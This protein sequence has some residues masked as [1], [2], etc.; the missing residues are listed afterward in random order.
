MAKLRRILMW[1]TL[2]GMVNLTQLAALSAFIGVEKAWVLFNSVPLMLSWVALT[3]ML[4]V[5]FT[6][7]RR[8]LRTPGLLAMHLGCVLI[9]VGGMLSSKLGLKLADMWSPH[10]RVFEGNM[11]KLYDGEFR[12]DVT[13]NMGRQFDELPFEIGCEKFAIEY[14]PYPLDHGKLSIAV[15]N[16]TIKTGRWR[17]GREKEEQ[18]SKVKRFKWK[19]DKWVKL[20]LGDDIEIRV[21]E[22][23]IQ[24]AVTEPFLLAKSPA[25][26][27]HAHG[28]GVQVIPIPRGAESPEFEVAGSHGGKLI[29]RVRRVYQSYWVPH[30]MMPGQLREVEGH[31]PG[32]KPAAE[33]ELWQH[34]GTTFVYTKKLMAGFG[35]EK[36][37]APCRYVPQDQTKAETGT[38]HPGPIIIAEPPGREKEIV[39]ARV[40]Q[41]FTFMPA[42]HMRQGVI[43]RIR[44]LCFVRLVGDADSP[45][46]PEVSEAVATDPGA[47]PA[48]EIDLLV[49][50]TPERAYSPGVVADLAR[51]GGRTGMFTYVGPDDPKKMK[52]M[53]RPI[54]TFQARRR[55]FIDERTITI[56]KAQQ[57]G[58]VH[59]DFLYDDEEAWFK[60]GAP[61]VFAADE[62]PIKEY[63][64]DL[65]IRKDG[66][67]VARGTIEVNEPMHYGGY[68]IYQ[69]SYDAYDLMYTT[70]S[71]KSDAGWSI[72]LG[73]M[74]L[75][76]LGT[77]IQFWF[78]PV[79]K[80]VK[81]RRGKGP[82]TGPDQGDQAGG[83]G[84][85]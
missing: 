36:F 65:V 30:P 63:T 61:R 1:M 84:D 35:E 54:I 43:A 34:R 33:L 46:G 11:K 41:E 31:D 72:V 23:R 4:V 15:S 78:A 75:L 71:V 59:L 50:R 28:A 52:G 21:T 80:V 73:G 32:S 7:Y 62:P 13:D 29:G 24:P 8:L 57:S 49:P 20:P 74:L 85:A 70:I 55:G 9:L 6:V 66:K 64:S 47:E 25:H 19:R 37:L 2:V 76:M 18:T 51:S 44:R 83:R 69:D 45:E 42:G 12:R 40:G 58:A 82:R 56:R 27:G 26:T 48:A 79:W 68:H 3:V 38:E 10:K 81:A 60:A 16:K 77:F 5:G 39:P 53:Q 14:Y 17:G 67:I 22:F